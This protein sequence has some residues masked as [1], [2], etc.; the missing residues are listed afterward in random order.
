MEAQE[1]ARALCAEIGRVF[2]GKQEQIRLIITAVFSGG[3][4]LL[5][6]LPGSGKTTLI[7]ALSRAL[8]CEARRVQFTPDLL[9]SDII[10]MSVYDQKSGE[11]RRVK[12]P[13]FSN[14]LLA[15][16]INRALPRTQSALLEAMEE[17]QVT[18]DNESFPLPEP[19]FVMATQNP[20]E[21]ES[22]F[23]LPAAQ[24]DRF[25][26]RLSL[27]FPD[28]DE[29][30]RMLTELGGEPDFSAVNI[31]T[32]PEQLMELRREIQA[33]H[34]SDSIAAY[35]V[36]LVHRTREHKLLRSGASPRAS[37]CLYQGG[38]AHAAVCGRDYV[39]PEDISALFL[40][41]LGHRVT[42]TNEARTTG[43]TAPDILESILCDTPV[44]PQ[45]GEMFDEAARK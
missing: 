8:G 44:P 10:G 32:G 39:T 30:R 7:K 5:D 38:K 20:V 25:F 33:V 19:F 31:V 27:G 26:V 1:C 41:V 14:I 45:R 13:V 11:F 37:R 12:G 15:D 29:E 34:V 6:D 17:R 22:T 16:E 28:R 9:P 40:P 21:R 2:V 36:D 24:L 35:I 4:V 23:Q 43:R 18:I 3:H 42:L